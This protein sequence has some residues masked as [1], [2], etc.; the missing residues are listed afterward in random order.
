MSKSYYGQN[1]TQTNSNSVIG[2]LWNHN[3]EINTME[4]IVSD[5]L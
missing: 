5:A 4:A 2:P 1:I 3:K